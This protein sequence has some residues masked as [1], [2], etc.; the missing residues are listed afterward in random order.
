[1]SFHRQI[2]ESASEHSC[3]ETHTCEQAF[4][5]MKLY[6]ATQRW[7][8]ILISL[9]TDHKHHIWLKVLGIHSLGS[10]VKIAIF[11]TNKHTT[12]LTSILMFL[13]RFL[14]YKVFENIALVF[15]VKVRGGILTASWKFSNITQINLWIVTNQLHYC[16]CQSTTWESHTETFWQLFMSD[17]HV[18]GK[19]IIL[20][21]ILE[22]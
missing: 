12:S 22:C 6:K 7:L 5:L 10:V 19:E 2:P 21:E 3:W 15:S 8:K 11:I 17:T 16:L 20:P 18:K 4:S 1:M 14:V 9:S 13:I